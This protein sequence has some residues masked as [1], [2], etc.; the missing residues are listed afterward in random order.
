MSRAELTVVAVGILLG[1]CAGWWMRGWYDKPITRAEPPAPAQRLD[2]GSLV[3]ERGEPGRVEDMPRPP[4]LPKNVERVERVVRVT[5]RPQLEGDG[6]EVERGVMSP[7]APASCPDVRVDLA[8]LEMTD[9]TRRVVASSPDGII[10]GGVDVPLVPVKVVA[11]P[12]LNALGLTFRPLTKAPGIFYDHDF[13][14]LR[15]GGVLELIPPGPTRAP[16]LAVMVKAG[17][18]F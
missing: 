15:V 4:E 3:L 1:V 5:V 16:E 7:A 6:R 12:L 18:R 17:W 13:A 14:R 11:P 9:G 10:L 8:L 2:G